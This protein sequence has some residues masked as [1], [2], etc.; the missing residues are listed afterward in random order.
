[1]IDQQSREMQDFA[2]EKKRDPLDETGA[3]VI[4]LY[5]FEMQ[6]TLNDSFFHVE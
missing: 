1:M 6:K 5:W 4:T 2:A 3:C